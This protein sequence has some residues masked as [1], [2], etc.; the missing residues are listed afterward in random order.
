[1]PLRI[2]LLVLLFLGLV[3]IDPSWLVPDLTD[4]HE[5]LRHSRPEDVAAGL[6]R[7]GAIALS[8]SQL[9]A[10]ALVGLGHV[11][12]SGRLQ[13]LGRRALLPVLRSGLPLALA[14]GTALPAAAAEVRLPIV[15][16]AVS[17]GPVAEVPLPAAEPSVIVQPG[18]SMWTIAE[19]RAN[20]PVGRYW[21]EV[22]DLN[23]LRFADV[24]LIHPGDVVLLPGHS[25]EG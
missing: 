21:L 2:L 25:R 1:M 20:G 22:V 4:L 16:P 15:P 13:Y 19:D 24:D 5:W 12:R 23:R 11:S 17:T 6:L 10:L 8:G 3:S 7:I 9:A 14:A 18:D